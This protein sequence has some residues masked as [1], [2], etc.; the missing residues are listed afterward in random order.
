MHSSAGMIKRL[1]LLLISMLFGISLFAQESLLYLE[2]QGVI[3]Y[4]N[5]YKNHGWYNTSGDNP[6]FYSHMPLEE[7]QKPSIGFDFLHRISGTNRDLAVLSLQFRLATNYAEK[8]PLEPQLYNAWIKYKAKV[9]DISI[10]HLRP[11]SGLSYTLDNHALLLP[12]MSMFAYSYD[13]DW[14]A[15]YSKDTEWGNV[16]ASVTSGSGMLLERK[17]GN[18]LAAAHASY[19]VLNRDNYSVGVTLQRGLILEGMGY[20]FGHN[21]FLHPQKLIGLDGQYRYN[22]LETAVDVYAGE[23]LYKDTYSILLRQGINLLPE[24]TLKLEAQGIW[25][26]FVGNH[27]VNYSLSATYKLTPDLALRTMYTFEDK[28]H[29][30][31][32]GKIVAQIYYYKS[33][34]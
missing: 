32:A 31:E 4:A 25:R 13:R 15:E 5:G 3:G 18:Y 30:P 17:H 24:E 28:T 27:F 12:D 26:Q 7:M 29:T 21:K 1:S 11:A 22:N 23:F 8:T 10:G 14:G 19:G 9:G 34:F 6:I 16:S 20:H 2:A 33:L